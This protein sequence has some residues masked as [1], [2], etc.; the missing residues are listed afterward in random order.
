[1]DSMVTGFDPR[2]SC[3]AF[4][5]KDVFSGLGVN[6]VTAGLAS[7]VPIGTNIDRHP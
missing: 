4:V 6:P 2:A 1:M 5:L 3:I 7:P